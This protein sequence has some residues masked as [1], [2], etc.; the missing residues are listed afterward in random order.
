LRGKLLCPPVFESAE[1][2]AA[3]HRTLEEQID[4]GEFE[5]GTTSLSELFA[6]SFRPPYT[7]NFHGLPTRGYKEKLAALIRPL[8]PHFSRQQPRS[9]RPRVGFVVT[10]GH[11]QLFLRCT[12]GIVERLDP[13]EFDVV[14][15]A[16]ARCL[17]VLRQRLAA[18]HVRFI[19][20]PLQI[21]AAMQ[22]LVTTECDVLY[23][24]EVS[25]DDAN[26][27]LPFAQ[28]APV[29]CTSW[30][31]QVT[32]GVKEVNYYLSSRWIESDAADQ[33]YTEKLWRLESLP[34]WQ[35]RVAAPLPTDKA[36]FNWPERQ[37]IYLCPQNLLKIHPDQDA[38]F[39]G[40]LEA[41][42]QALIVLKQFRYPTAARLLSERLQ[43]HLGSLAD[44]VVFLPWLS[45]ADYY[46]L[47]SVADVVLD[48][49]HYS[50][51]SSS[52][53]MF[54]LAQPIVTLPTELNVGRYTLACYR[55]MEFTELVA[56]DAAN[57]VRLAV[58]VAS[59]ADYRRHV[60]DELRTRSEVLFEDASAVAAHADFF[61]RAVAE[62]EAGG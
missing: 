51:G 61:R 16:S 39:R 52:Y 48:A 26:Y 15:L 28:A 27:L 43:R 11:E 45:Q 37:H 44:R 49:V 47:V 13:R 55:R 1:A 41:D 4:D 32:S 23:H 30:G 22:T 50:A 19:P 59:D 20:L 2:I 53:D 57:Y 3:F 42:P 35:R 8:V 29:Q 18:P 12:G 36:Y 5:L 58:A 56:A 34:T 9:G 25:S 38:L 54:S 33:H 6:S 14:V 21:E 40:I 7:M 10:P 62:A 46:R 24:W 17:P 31:T 60:R